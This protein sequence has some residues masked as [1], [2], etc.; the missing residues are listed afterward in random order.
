MNRYQKIAWFNL[1][2]IAAA[3]VVTS[4]AI[5]VEFHLRGYATIGLFSVGILVLLKFTPLLFKKP[6]GRSGVVSDERDD[7][8]LT[9]AV[10]RAWTVF[11][12]VLVVSCFLLW[13][14]IGPQNSV[15]TIALPLIAFGGAL[16][17]K[18]VC[19]VAIL[20]QYGR[21]VTDGR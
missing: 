2:V 6:Q 8:I 17:H 19:S 14:I 12:W 11:W 1:I 10:T 9:R 4:V 18:V 16:V 13:F 21:E 20:V 7:L 3:I 15:P 5:V